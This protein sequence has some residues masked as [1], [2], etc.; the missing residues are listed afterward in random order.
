MQNFTEIGQSAAELW[1]KKTTFKSAD[2]RR[3]EFLKCSY[4]VMAATQFQM[5]L[6]VL[7]FTKFHQNWMIFR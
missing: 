4:L 7:L 6:T 3:L 1:P 2:V 5:L